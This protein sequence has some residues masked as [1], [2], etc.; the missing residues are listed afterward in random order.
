MIL[1]C[2]IPT[3][4]PLEMVA[5]ELRN[6]SVPF[7]WFNQ[8]LFA[9]ADITFEI[10][11]DQV[12]GQLALEGRSY[13]LEEFS[14]VYTRLMDDRLLPELR[15]EPVHSPL[16]RSCRA[17]HDTLMHWCEVAPGRVV[18][19]N[20]PMASNFSKPY[21]A[22]LIREQ[23][24]AVPETLITNDPEL[25]REFHRRHQRVIYKSISGI[26][27]IVKV[28]E[29]ADFE[30]LDHI[31]WCPIQ[32]QAFIEGINVRVHTVA[33]EVFATEIC[34][35]V[36]DYRYAHRQGG[37]A[38]LRAIEL[39]SALSERCLML[40]QALHL[41]FAGIDLKI[42]PAGEVFCF[43]VNPSPAFSFF[44]TSTGQPIARAIARYLAGSS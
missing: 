26:R 18:N 6:L 23:G 27:S 16:R 19:R 29:N 10:S 11:A 40:S 8:R 13:R 7:V 30:R 21:Q 1:L 14:G 5:Q 24:F 34:S 38:Q 15:N 44:E 4:S 35:D 2:G 36:T 37:Q 22:Q 32:F 41:P 42:T 33:Q 9:A 12:L 20:G 31:R 43:E 39:A 28:L 25:V 3:E 17:L